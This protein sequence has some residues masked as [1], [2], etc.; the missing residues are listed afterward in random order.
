MMTMVYSAEASGSVSRFST[1]CS[2]LFNSK[3]N[4]WCI[5]FLQVAPI[6]DVG[7]SI[8]CISLNI[9]YIGVWNKLLIERSYDRIIETGFLCLNLRIESLI[10]SKCYS[11][12]KL[13]EHFV[14]WPLE[15]SI[16][17]LRKYNNCNNSHIRY[18]LMT[19]KTT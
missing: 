14:Y 2:P 3:S 1:K 13:I 8:A 12:K 17:N 15:M 7:H 5:A 11:I 10:V 19:F 9:S 16:T 4:Q 18:N 6:K